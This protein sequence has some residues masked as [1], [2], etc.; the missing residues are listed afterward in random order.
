MAQ[1][2][3]GMISLVHLESVADRLVGSIDDQFRLDLPSLE[4]DPAVLE[5]LG[6]T[7]TGLQSIRERVDEEITTVAGL[8]G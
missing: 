8:L 2:P 1:E 7:E 6:L 5:V 3:E 4:I